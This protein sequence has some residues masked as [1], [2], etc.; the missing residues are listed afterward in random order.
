MV[1]QITAAV[2][3]K[4]ISLG[5]FIDLSKTFDTINHSI[6]LDYYCIMASAVLHTIGFVLI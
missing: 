6:L 2:D 4:K 3:A 1:D 5:I